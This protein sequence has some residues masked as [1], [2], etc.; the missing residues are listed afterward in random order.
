MAVC[1]GVGFSLFLGAISAQPLLLL[2]MHF[3]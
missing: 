2:R 1:H 3:R